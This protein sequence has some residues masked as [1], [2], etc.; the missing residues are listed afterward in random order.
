MS[1][2]QEE[3][4]VWYMKN[5]TNKKEEVKDDNL[6]DVIVC[7]KVTMIVESITVWRKV[8]RDRAIRLQ[9]REQSGFGGDNI[10]VCTLAEK[11][12]MGREISKEYLM[13]L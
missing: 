11:A 7:N 13:K 4:G 10:V 8:S 9:E 1:K 3:L 12:I 2:V 6:Y 5:K